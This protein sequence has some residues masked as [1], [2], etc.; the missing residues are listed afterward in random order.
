MNSN[1][2]SFSRPVRYGIIG[3]GG[4]G[5]RHAAALLRHKGIAIV[6]C[7]DSDSLRCR[8]LAQAF[9]IPQSYS[10]AEELLGQERLDA[11]SI[12]TGNDTHASL[13]ILAL[14]AGCHVLCEK[15]M[16]RTAQEA[17]P[18]L[19]AA[20]RS[21]RMLTVGHYM[22]YL[23]QTIALKHRLAAGDLGTIHRIRCLGLRRAGV[24]S[25]GSFH[26]REL[27]GGGPL[28]DT[29][30]HT[31]DLVLDLVNWPRAKTVSGIALH[32]RVPAANYSN[33]P[34]YGPINPQNVNTEDLAL[35]LIRLE[36]GPAL[37]LEVSWAGLMPEEEDYAQ[38]LMGDQAGARLRPFGPGPLLET[39]HTVQGLPVDVAYDIPETTDVYAPQMSHWIKCLQG[40]AHP[41]VLP[42]Q[43]LEVLRILDGIY[44][45]AAEEREVVLATTPNPP[46]TT[47]DS[48][49][50]APTWNA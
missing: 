32:H 34:A 4:M 18:M 2:N 8:N 1:P 14:E 45:S 38:V 33:N 24:P 3:C 26:R 25:W 39:F 41:V 48:V 22:R 43:C 27:S 17:A 44:D 6:A 50:G 13:S 28:L 47:Y 30:V 37:T 20:R 29:A 35:G 15:P 49:R 19:E 12:C 31:L 42:E 36:R 9:N 40:Q 16:A 11:V 10:T 46:T 5:H 7:A 23:P 21:G